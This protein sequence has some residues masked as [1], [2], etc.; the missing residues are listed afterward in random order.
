ML[1][2]YLSVVTDGTDG[3]GGAQVTICTAWTELDYRLGSAYKA[4]H[5]A[6]V[7]NQL[8]FLLL[9]NKTYKKVNQ[10]AKQIT[11]V[12]YE[13][14]LDVALL[15][16]IINFFSQNKFCSINSKFNK[17][18]NALIRIFQLICLYSASA[19]SA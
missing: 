3:S 13:E 6:A 9:K 16:A 15:V 11:A 2:L 4:G 14:L 7:F 19:Y 12:K 18:L 17:Y 1:Y 10:A 8:F 5:C